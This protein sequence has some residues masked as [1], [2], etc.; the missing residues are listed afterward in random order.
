MTI[1]FPLEATLLHL[2]FRNYETNYGGFS[3]SV[4][5]GSCVTALLVF[6]LSFLVERWASMMMSHLLPRTVFSLQWVHSQINFSRISIMVQ[7]LRDEIADLQVESDKAAEEKRLIET[8][9]D[10]LQKS[11]ARSKLPQYFVMILLALL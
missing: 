8:Q 6:L 11:I 7:P 5:C 4:S 9:I 3:S 2:T 1:G 10:D